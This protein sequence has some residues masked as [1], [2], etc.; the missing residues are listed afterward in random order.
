M[1][2]LSI[3]D[4]NTKKEERVQELRIGLTKVGDEIQITGHSEGGSTWYLLTIKFDGTFCR[5]QSVS[6]HIGLQVDDDGR[7]KES[8]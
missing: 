1:I 2:K 6:S 7:I 3:Y 4:E 8:E 5:C